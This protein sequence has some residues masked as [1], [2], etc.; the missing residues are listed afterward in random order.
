M[1]I[2]KEK[3]KIKNSKF[4]LIDKIHYRGEIELMSTD[5]VLLKIKE[6]KIRE[7]TG[8]FNTVT[9]SFLANVK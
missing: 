4:D 9:C 2:R 7:N 8:H 5:F 3:N 1:K 6:K